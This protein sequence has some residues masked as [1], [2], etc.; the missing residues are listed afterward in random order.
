MWAW[1]FLPGN[2][3]DWGSF[4]SPAQSTHLLS[5]K[6]TVHLVP[7][8]LHLSCWLRRILQ[9]STLWSITRISGPVSPSC[10][11]CKLS[12][13]FFALHSKTIT[14]V[15]ACLFT[16]YLWPAWPLLITLVHSAS[17]GV[18]PSHFAIISTTVPLKGIPFH[19]SWAVCAS[20]L[21]A[22]NGGKVV[23]CALAR[24]ETIMKVAS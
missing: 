9:H 16:C 4:I 19:S 23:G 20:G 17:A 1:C 11:C 5:I 6:P 2:S 7:F 8:S 12:A 10:L 13:I 14:H 24:K 22:Q 3:T 15:P 18:L 21:R